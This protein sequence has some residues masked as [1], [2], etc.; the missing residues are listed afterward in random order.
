MNP[1]VEEVFYDKPTI[2][3]KKT[4]VTGPFTL[5][6]FL[7]LLQNHLKKLK[8]ILILKQIFQFQEVV[9]HCDKM[10]GEM[11]YFVQV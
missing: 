1:T 9:K 6:Q 11:N 2:N 3:N 5:K 8:Q 4:R 10:N 7:P